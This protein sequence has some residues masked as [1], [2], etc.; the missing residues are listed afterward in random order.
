MSGK[1]RRGKGS[2]WEERHVAID[3]RSI[4]SWPVVHHGIRY[5]VVTLIKGKFEARSPDGFLAGRF[6]TLTDAYNT[7]L[8]RPGEGGC[9]G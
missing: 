7:L 2:R 6:T 1:V 9:C 4:H 5:G 8:T 3:P